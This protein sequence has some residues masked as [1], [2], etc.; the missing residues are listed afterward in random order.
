MPPLHHARC[1]TCGAV[2]AVRRNG[3]MREHRGLPESTDLG[4]P[5]PAVCPG[6]GQPAYEP[7]QSGC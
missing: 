7:P 6:S 3:T 5:V 2:Y 1:G 4:A